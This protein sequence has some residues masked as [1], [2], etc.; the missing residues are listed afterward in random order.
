[1]GMSIP[2]TGKLTEPNLHVKLSMKRLT[3]SNLANN[4]FRANKLDKPFKTLKL[5]YNKKHFTGFTWHESS[6]HCCE[7]RAIGLL[8]E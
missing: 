3:D 4:H 5:N 6:K 2:V 7:W 8:T 1:M